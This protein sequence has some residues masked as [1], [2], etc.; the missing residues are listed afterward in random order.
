MDKE[1]TFNTNQK[2]VIVVEVN[3]L[4]S[5]NVLEKSKH[6]GK[7]KESVHYLGS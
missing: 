4:S 5:L 1:L 6:A 3:F 7:S 2:Y